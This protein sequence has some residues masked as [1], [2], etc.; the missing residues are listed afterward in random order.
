MPL[1]CMYWPHLDVLSCILTLV[2]Q[3][4]WFNTAMKGRCL[5]VFA[6]LGTVWFAVPADNIPLG[7]E[8]SVG[9]SRSKL[10]A[11]D[12]VFHVRWFL[13]IFRPTQAA[14]AGDV[15]MKAWMGK[16][17]KG[18]AHFHVI[19]GARIFCR[20]FFHS[21]HSIAA[22]SC[23]IQVF[24]LHPQ[25]QRTEHTTASLQ[26]SRARKTVILDR[27]LLTHFKTSESESGLLTRCLVYTKS[28]IGRAWKKQEI[29]FKWMYVNIYLYTSHV[30]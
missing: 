7:P 17:N 1:S 5:Q 24:L 13:K 22:C 4:Q 27:N 29:Y 28:A 9:T 30:D 15:E 11:P 2:F 14:A 6:C 18:Q 16:N 23:F 12:H 21:N 10:F 8:R 25:A 26:S 20:W 19:V 3:N